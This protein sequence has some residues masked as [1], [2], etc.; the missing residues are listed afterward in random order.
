MT[1]TLS[2]HS[3]LRL[4]KKIKSCQYLSVLSVSLHAKGWRFLESSFNNIS[5]KGLFFFQK[6][7]DRT[8]YSVLS[9]CFPITSFLTVWA[10]LTSKSL[11]F[12]N[13]QRSQLISECVNLTPTTRGATTS[14]FTVHASRTTSPTC[15]AAT[16]TTPPSNTAATRLSSRWSCSSTS[17]PPQTVMH[18]SKQKT[19]S[20]LFYSLALCIC[21]N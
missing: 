8:S 12:A 17:P 9:V 15:S 19:K 20:L 11:F 14:A 5:N 21:P 10:N 1:C 6:K 13:L 2:S 7:E 3:F 16:T 18:T 4:P